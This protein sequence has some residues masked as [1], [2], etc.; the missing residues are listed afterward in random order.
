MTQYDVMRH[1]ADSWG[2]LLMFAF[3]IGAVLFVFR[4]GSK[5]RYEDAAKIPLKNGSED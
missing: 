5:A 3:F 1:F 2:L 4:P